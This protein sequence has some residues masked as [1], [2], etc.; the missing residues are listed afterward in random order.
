MPDQSAFC[1]CLALNNGRQW[2][3]I[4]THASSQRSPAWPSISVDRD[5]LWT[6]RQFNLLKPLVEVNTQFRLHRVSLTYTAAQWQHTYFFLRRKAKRTKLYFE[7]ICV[8]LPIC[9]CDRVCHLLDSRTTS[10]NS[11]QTCPSKRCFSCVAYL[12]PIRYC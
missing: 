5:T 1:V 10:T 3:T 6:Y 4:S 8:H 12:R 9:V 2:R 11:F 7:T